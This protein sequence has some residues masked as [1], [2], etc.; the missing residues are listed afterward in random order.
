MDNW[1]VFTWRCRWCF[2]IFNNSLV[3]SF[4][5]STTNS[6]LNSYRFDVKAHIWHILWSWTVHYAIELEMAKKLAPILLQSNMNSFVISITHNHINY[7]FFVFK[8]TLRIQIGSPH[9]PLW[10][11]TFS[12]SGCWEVSHKTTQIKLSCTMS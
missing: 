1:L 3:G 12:R 7:E 10:M 6:L 8:H 4:I 9:Y 2:I 11:S 5:Y